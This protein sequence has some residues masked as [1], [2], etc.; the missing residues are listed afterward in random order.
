VKRLFTSF[1][2]CGTETG[3]TT[4]SKL[5]PPLTPE[6]EGI[7]FQTLTKFSDVGAD[8]RSMLIPD[9]GY[10]FIEADKSQAE[11]RLVALL[12]RD[13]YALHLFDM[14]DKTKL[15]EYDIHRVT[16]SWLES[17]LTP[18]KM[19]TAQRQLGKITR[20]M[21]N[22]DGGKHR[23]AITA[24][25]S[26]WKAGKALELFHKNSPNIRGVFYKEIQDALG[27][28]N[29]VIINPFGRPRQFLGKWGDDIFKEAY[30]QIPQ[31]T[32]PDALKRAM[33]RMRAEIPYYG[34]HWFFCMESHD[35]FTALVREEIVDLFCPCAKTIMEEPIDFARCTLSR[36]SIIIPSDFKIGR[37]NLKDLEDYKFSEVAN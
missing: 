25:V 8:L 19:T 2:F 10:V 27:H 4:T 12:A 32:I 36:G 23:L 11:A 18:T 15:P 16:G 13:E 35:S 1:N 31:S 21:G 26:E 5:K 24:Q 34:K 3:R 6:A 9:P 7:A 20:H 17:G 14:F 28:N 37:T 30:A 22:Y 33:L 29:R